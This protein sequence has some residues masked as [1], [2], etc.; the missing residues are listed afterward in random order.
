MLK[1]LLRLACALPPALAAAGT[2]AQPAARSGTVN[3]PDGPL[4]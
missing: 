3:T 4:Y 1:T 2:G